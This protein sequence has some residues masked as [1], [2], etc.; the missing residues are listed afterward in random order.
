M[1]TFPQAVTPDPTPVHPVLIDQVEELQ[2]LQ[3]AA[4][5][6]TSRTS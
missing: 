2:K 1:A 5:K 4:Q 3:K 6:I